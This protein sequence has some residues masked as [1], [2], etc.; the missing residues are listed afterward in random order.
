MT[1]Q[2]VATAL[3]RPMRGR[4]VAATRCT[5]AFVAGAVR[6]QCAPGRS[7]THERRGTYAVAGASLLEGLEHVAYPE[8]GVFIFRSS[9][10]HL[11]IRCGGA[12]RNEAAAHVHEDQ[13]SFDLVVDCSH[14]AADPGTYV[15]TGS[16]DWRRR[17][18]SVHAHYAPAVAAPTGKDA[19]FA[20]PRCGTDGEAVEFGAA[21]FVGYAAVPGGAVR[22]T[23]QV[24]A[25]GIDVVDHY[26]LEP[27]YV[28]AGD[29]PLRP[30]RPV[31][32]SPGYGVRLR[33]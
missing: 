14:A 16:P 28:P 2:A 29:D 26:E 15:Y 33:E 21:R 8:F 3:V 23:I 9:R 7:A 12:L 5:P 18:R 17:Y 25:N 31:P 19:L 4:A 6:T 10:L 22:R 24:R 27:P 1:A 20:R 13:L 11:V 32:Y 30:A